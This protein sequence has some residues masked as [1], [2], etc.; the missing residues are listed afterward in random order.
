MEIEDLKPVLESPNGEIRQKAILL[1]G[2]VYGRGES[3]KVRQK[4]R[5]RLSPEVLR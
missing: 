3:G 4:E 1:L 5:A 2:E